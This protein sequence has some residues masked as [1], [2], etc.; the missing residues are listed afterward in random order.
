MTDTPLYHPAPLPQGQIDEGQIIL[1]DDAT[2]ELRPARPDDPDPALLCLR[3]LDYGAL[4]CRTMVV[5]AIL[6]F[7]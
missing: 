4:S 5:G 1:R 6:N 7:V 3:S 2:A